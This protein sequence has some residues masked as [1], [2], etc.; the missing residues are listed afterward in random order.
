MT[1]NNTYYYYLK[2]L[3]FY[4]NIFV[5]SKKEVFEA[6]FGAFVQLGFSL[7]IPHQHVYLIY[8]RLLKLLHKTSRS[9]L[10]EEMDSLLALDIRRNR[11]N[12]NNDNQQKQAAQDKDINNNLNVE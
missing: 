9:Y 7:H 1:L 5:N 2:F 6:E 4:C 12:M 10:G 8:T 3:Y 11:E